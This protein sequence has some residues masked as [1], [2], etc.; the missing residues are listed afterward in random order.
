VKDYELS[1]LYKPG[2]KITLVV[3]TQD[4]QQK[5]IEFFPNTT[6]QLIPQ[7]HIM[8]TQNALM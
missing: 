5:I 6:Y 4:D 7:Y 2:K 3:E 1:A 8:P